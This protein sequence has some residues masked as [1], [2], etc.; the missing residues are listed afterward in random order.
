MGWRV[1]VY[2]IVREE[3]NGLSSSGTLSRR[4]ML[5]AYNSLR[6]ELPQQARNFQNRRD[7]TDLDY[8]TYKVRFHDRDRW[9]WF[10]FYVND[11]V[12]PGLLIVE[13]LEHRSSGG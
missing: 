12:E 11:R 4:G 9:H 5:L 6:L 10:T 2:P 13:D 7:P 3:L 1:K 8:F